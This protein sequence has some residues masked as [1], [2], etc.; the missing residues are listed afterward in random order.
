LMQMPEPGS[1]DAGVVLG[2]SSRENERCHQRQSTAK[3][4]PVKQPA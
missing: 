2:A 3:K 1:V 4:R